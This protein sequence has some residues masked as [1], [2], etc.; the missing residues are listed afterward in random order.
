[1]YSGIPYASV[2]EGRDIRLTQLIDNMS[3][4]GHRQAVNGRKG[5]FTLTGESF[6]SVYGQDPD[7][8]IFY[9]F[10]GH[11]HF[12]LGNLLLG[13]LKLAKQLLY[14]EG[15]SREI[16]KPFPCPAGKLEVLESPGPELDEFWRRVSPH[17]RICVKRDFTFLKWR[18]FDHP[19]NR[20]R[21]YVWRDFRGR[22]RAYAVVLF[23]DRYA[24]IVDLAA[25]P[26]G[27]EVGRIM[28]ALRKECRDQGVERIRAWISPDNFLAD[29]LVNSG[30]APGQEPTGIILTGRILSSGRSIDRME[31]NIFC[32]MGDADLF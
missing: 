17:F 15:E 5:L 10:P 21:F 6:F 4:P 23:R 12:K 29:Q 14:L 11:R 16:R 19:S 25:I 27:R 26:R 28:A 9:G 31:R 2:W 18:Y 3:H 24:T 22:I 13:Y 8:D 1:M 32:T 30:L 7:S 20:Y